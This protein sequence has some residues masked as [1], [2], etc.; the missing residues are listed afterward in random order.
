MEERSEGCEQ[1]RLSCLVEDAEVEF[2]AADRRVVDPKTSRRDDRTAVERLLQRRNVAAE[3]SGHH[4]GA[5]W[6]NFRVDSGKEIII[7]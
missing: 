3:I 4:F 7:F 6:Q 1:Q 2:P 5:V